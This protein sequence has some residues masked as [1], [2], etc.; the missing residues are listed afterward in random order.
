VA[1]HLAG[2]T[3]IGIGLPKPPAQ[4]SQLGRR[5]Q[6]LGQNGQQILV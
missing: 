5:I 3:G 2:Q 1:Q 4:Q 6:A